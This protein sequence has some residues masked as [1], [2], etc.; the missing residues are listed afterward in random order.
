MRHI[1]KPWFPQQLRAVIIEP[2][3]ELARQVYAQAIKLSQDLEWRV[4][5]LGES[6]LS[7]ETPP[8]IIIATPQRFAAAI[9]DKSIS[10]G[11]VETLCFDEADKL[12]ELDFLR[13][14]DSILMA[15]SNPQLRKAMFS[16][17]VPSGFEEMVRRIVGADL[18]RVIVGHKDGN[19]HIAQQLQ[20]C[21]TEEGKLATLKDLITNGQFLP[22]ALIFVQSVERAKEL[23]KQLKQTGV[24]V[25]V[26]HS[27]LTK[28]Q[29][30]R[31]VAAFAV[32][33]IWCLV[34]TEV[35]ARGVDFKAVNM[36]IK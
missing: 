27:D 16:A 20:F 25:G 6:D 15:C 17:T 31:A 26:I 13:Q 5:L 11:A 24:H 9:R 18:V 14:S 21:A 36:V 28:T 2:T 3:R 12:F 30:A 7:S 34:S 33:E 1:Q 19:T 32:G 4:C 29:R 8:D 23:E 10:A 35:M 22:P